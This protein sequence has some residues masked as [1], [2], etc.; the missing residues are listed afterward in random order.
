MVETVILTASTGTFPGLVDALREIPV[1]V[2]EQ[3]LITF[4]PPHDESAVDAALGRAGSYAA[5]AFTSPRAAEAVV[6]RIKSGQRSWR[7]GDNTPDVWAIGPATASAL[8]PVLGPVRV[9][10]SLPQRKTGTAQ[11]LAQAMLAANL[12]G[13]VLFFCGYLRRDELPKELRNAGIEVDEVVC[14]RSVLADEST[15]RAVA[16]R[17]SVLVV[18]SPS[19]V[20]LLARSCAKPYRADLLAVGP[21]TAAKAY[22]VGWAP[23]AVADEPTAG[24]LASALRSMLANR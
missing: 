2:E 8:D 1:E 20:D 21:T 9:P 12:S 3:P 5:V 11:A 13:P 4:A 23:A 10:V 7:F 18:A 14:Y 6:Q 19:V 16:A 24:A 15:A 17:G 22:A